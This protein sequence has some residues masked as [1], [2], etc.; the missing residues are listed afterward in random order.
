MHTRGWPAPAAGDVSGGTQVQRVLNSEIVELAGPERTGL[1]P[2][3]EAVAGLRGHRRKPARAWQRFSHVEPA[4][5]PRALTEVV[6]KVV[7][8]ARK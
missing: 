3:F 7:A 5:V 4:R 2:D 1:A 8:L 6:E